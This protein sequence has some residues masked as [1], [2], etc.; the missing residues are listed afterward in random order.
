MTPPVSQTRD[1][2]ANPTLFEGESVVMKISFY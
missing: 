2:E 1:I